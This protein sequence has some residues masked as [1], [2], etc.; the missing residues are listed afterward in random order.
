MIHLKNKVTILVAVLVCAGIMGAVAISKKNS[1]QHDYT[2]FMVQSQSAVDS[3]SE[4]ATAPVAISQSAEQQAAKTKAD[5][6]V[7]AVLFQSTDQEG[8]IGTYTGK[9]IDNPADNIFTISLDRTPSENDRVWLCYELAGVNDYTNIPHSINDQR[10]TGGYLVQLSDKASLQREQVNTAW[11]K[12]GENRITF[13]LP[14]DA[15]FGY[16]VSNLSIEIE[17]GANIPELVVNTSSI[18]YDNKAYISGFVQIKDSKGLKVV[19]D[20]KETVVYNGGFEAITA[21]N[22]N[23]LVIV[24]AILP[25]GKELSKTIHFAKATS[26]DIEFAFDNTTKQVGK[27]FKKGVADKLEIETAVLKVD[28]KS[29]LPDSKSI[30]VTTLR[31]IDM[32]A[33]DMGMSNVTDQYKG[34]RFLPHGEHF[35]KGTKVAIKYD[36]TKIPNGYTED[37]IRTYYFDTDTKH[38]VALERDTI[39][40]TNCMIVSNTTHFTDM[41]NGVIQSP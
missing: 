24:K 37:D 3:D 26:A 5:K 14:E 18:S 21:L 22:T 9:Q 15:G 35:G 1:S 31:H 38:W 33:L 8:F 16:K 10:A 17:Q 13:S 36:R 27:T 30:T 7:D 23:R 28:A 34:Y 25:D 2:A 29:L 39:D 6:S 20:G 40:K 11:L 41:I 12:K 32:A 4:K 19:V